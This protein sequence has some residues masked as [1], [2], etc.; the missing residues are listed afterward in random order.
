MKAAFILTLMGSGAAAYDDASTLDT[1]TDM[2][3]FD[4]EI[5]SQSVGRIVFGLFGDVVPKTVKNFVELADGDLGIGIRGDYE[6]AYKDSLF[7]RIIP[8]FMA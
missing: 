8:E 5:D 4:V 7:H 2:V 3:Y 1:V 6:L